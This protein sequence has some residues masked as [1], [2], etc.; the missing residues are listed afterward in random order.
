MVAGANSAIT[1]DIIVDDWKDYKIEH[2]IQWTGTYDTLFC[3]TY[4]ALDVIGSLFMYYLKNNL[5]SPENV[6]LWLKITDI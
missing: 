5:I 2:E 4:S 6:L 1:H 3:V